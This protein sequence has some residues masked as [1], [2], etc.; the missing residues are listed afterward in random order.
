MAHYFVAFL[1]INKE[2]FP[3]SDGWCS[4]PGKINTEDEDDDDG[5]VKKPMSL[6]PPL[7]D[8]FD[9]SRGN[10]KNILLMAFLIR[11]PLLHRDF[12]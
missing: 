7:L 8:N 12:L 4:S 5:G 9:L 2:N 3:F 10:F 1:K 11:G 6:L